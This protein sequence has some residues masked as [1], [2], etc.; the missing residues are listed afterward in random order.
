MHHFFIKISL[1]FLLPL[2]F[3]LHG[4]IW[5]STGVSS[6]LMVYLIKLSYLPIV[7]S[8][9]FS[10]G[11]SKDVF[12]VLIGM[13]LII[14]GL[15]GSIFSIQDL[16]VKYFLAD[17][18]GFIV[19]WLSFLAVS[20]YVKQGNEYWWRMVSW[21]VG[22]TFMVSIVV[23]IYYFASGGDKVSIPPEIHFGAAIIIGLLLFYPDQ[24]TTTNLIKFGVIL[25]A[26][27]LSQQRINFLVIFV[28]VFVFVLHRVR[29]PLA[30]FRFFLALLIVAL[31]IFFVF[32]SLFLN[33]FMRMKFDISVGGIS[34]QDNSANQRFI[35]AKLIME[36]VGRLPMFQ[37]LVGKGFG[38]EYA[39]TGDV[40]VHLAHSTPFVLLLRNGVIGVFLFFV[41]CFS[42]LSR[43]FRSNQHAVASCGVLAMLMAMMF[44]QY[45]YWGFLFAASLA[46]CLYIK[47]DPC[48]MP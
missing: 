26:C 44:D 10:S 28:P 39:N 2:F 19:L 48:R 6:A 9:S 41:I 47:S 13:L 30:L 46:L 37:V 11:F 38:A 32:H 7:V 20:S 42:A 16:G 27:I 5:V 18:F 15:L 22:S 21:I 25:A 17:L 12:P 45:V 31:V 43:L 4:W 33:L 36:E 23:V 8:L 1:F 24:R 34:F 29:N 14:C 40:S 3:L 35:E